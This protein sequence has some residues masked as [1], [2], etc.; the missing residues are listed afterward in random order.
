MTIAIYSRKSKF[1]GKGESIENQI[2]KCKKFIEYKFH[3]ICDENDIEIYIDEGFSGKNEN[4]PEYQKM[5][6]RVKNN[7]IDKIIIYQL[8]RLGRNARDIHNTMEMCTELDCI[9]YSAT[10]GFDSSTSFGRAV[11][12]ILASLAQLERD[13][14]VERVKDNMY[15]LAKT[16][17]WLGGN[18]PFGFTSTRE[19]YK[20]ENLKERSL[21][22]LKKD[23]EEFKI[24]KILFDKYLEL[25]SLSA[26]HHWALKNNVIGRFGGKFSKSILKNIFENPAYVKSTP[27]VVKYLESK[28]YEV[29]GEPNGNGIL[30]Y[31]KD[32]KIAAISRHKGIIDADKWLMIQEI[33]K[34]NSEKAPRI[35]KTKTSLLSGILRCKCSASM[36]ITY[37]SRV[38]DG[39]KPYYYVC[40]AKNTSAGILC[41]SKNLNGFKTDQ[42]IIEQVR[43]IPYDKIKNEFD[44]LML[45]TDPKNLEKDIVDIEKQR[46]NINAQI[47]RLISKLSLT[48]DEEVSKILL[49]QVKELKNKL[50][51]IDEKI[52]AT[53]ESQANIYESHQLINEMYSK[54]KDF[55]ENFDNMTIEEKK[56]LLREIFEYITWDSDTNTINFGFN[57]KKN[58][59]KL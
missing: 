58:L 3:D 30:R 26:V 45:N 55:N 47:S 28:N 14:L 27:E 16:G 2:I 29:C 32:N 34:D 44:L 20:D 13:Q 11:I 43:N 18:P 25:K 48:D 42:A 5:I 31:G 51:E 9:I 50:N 52:Q 40:S 24:V 1:T 15:T 56:N 35:G 57:L 54:L 59:M 22:I 10:E 53:N 36:R 6:S 49:D 33:F 38:V 41:K 8:N 17:R 4:R 12:G 23:P 21:S 39:K 19:V 37:S 46:T 7:E